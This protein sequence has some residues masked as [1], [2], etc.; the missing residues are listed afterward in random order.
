MTSTNYDFQIIIVGGRNS[1]DTRAML[2]CVHSHY[3]PNKVLILKDCESPDQGF[4]SQRMKLLQTLEAQDG[5]ATAYVCENNTCSL[6]V[7][8]VSDLQQLISQ[9]KSHL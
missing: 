8:T 5:R 6:P 3:L 9:G 7:N 1:A 4:L 2:R